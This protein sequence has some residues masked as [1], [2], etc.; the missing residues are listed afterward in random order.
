MTHIVLLE[1]L[2]KVRC[3]SLAVYLFCHPM[4]SLAL[5]RFLSYVAN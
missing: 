3:K 2:C 1:V 4:F 5:K